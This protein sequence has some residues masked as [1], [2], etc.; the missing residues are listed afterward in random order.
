M[1]SLLVV[2]QFNVFKKELFSD[3]VYCSQFIVTEKIDGVLEI[4]EVFKNQ[5]GGIEY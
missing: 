2:I 5:T 3:L 4:P 1:Q